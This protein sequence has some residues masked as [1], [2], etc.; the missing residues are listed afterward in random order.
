MR[1][2]KIVKHKIATEIKESYKNKNNTKYILQLK[3]FLVLIKILNFTFSPFNK[4]LQF[5]VLP[6]FSVTTFGLCF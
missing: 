3:K 1:Y 2:N 4:L 6:M 5:V